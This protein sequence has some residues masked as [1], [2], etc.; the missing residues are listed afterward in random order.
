MA[1]IDATAWLSRVGQDPTLPFKYCSIDFYSG[2]F[3]CNDSSP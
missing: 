3:D 1:P 2:L